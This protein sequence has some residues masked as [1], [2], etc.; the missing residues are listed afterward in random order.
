[1]TVLLDKIKPEILALKSRPFAEHEIVKVTNSGLDRTLSEAT[2]LVDQYNRIGY[3]VYE[4]ETQHPGEQCVYELAELLN[5]G[6]PIF[7]QLYK[8]IKLD[9]NH[10]LSE[11]TS[12][13]VESKHNVFHSEN[14]QDLHCDGTLFAIGEIP[15]TI[16]HCEQI[17]VS[18]GETTAL[19]AVAAFVLLLLN[20][21]DAADALLHP[22]SLKRTATLGTFESHIGPAFRIFEGEVQSRL[23]LDNTA[24]WNYGFERV[25]HLERAVSFIQDLA[26]PSSPYFR[27]FQ[28]HNGQGILMAND[29]ILHGRTA[30]QNSHTVRRKLLRGLYGNRPSVI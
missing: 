14:G 27:R 16:L 22:E 25:P 19:D 3:A 13:A 17:A 30:F 18:G 6:E 8:S 1:M 9:S 26:Q 12:A 21:P 23:T 7:P 5:L 28:L 2:Q 4:M 29:K 20:D 11:I 10:Q 15:T 24:D